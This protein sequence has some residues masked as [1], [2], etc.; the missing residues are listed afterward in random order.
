MA[1]RST[2]PLSRLGGAWFSLCLIGL[3]LFALPGMVLLALNLLRMESTVNVWLK[4]K[5][6]ITYHIAVPWYASL[7]LVLV[8][9]LIVLLYFLKLKRKPLQV[10]STFLWKK[11]IEDLHVNS[12][13]Q[14][15]REN[16]LLLLQVLTVL[17]LIYSVLSFQLHGKDNET[18]RFIL[19]IDNS[20]S[21]SATDVA[22]SRLEQAKTEALTQVDEHG[23]DDSGM[24]IV[25]NSSAEIRQ[26]YTN[27]KGSLRR[28][29][30]SIEQTMR[31]TRVDEALTLAD[32][33]ANPQRSA[34]DK[35]GQPDNVEPGQ[36]RTIAAPE[37][38]PTEVHLYS[39]GR[40]P[41]VPDFVLGNLNMQFHAI[42]QPGPGSVDNVAIVAFN[43]VR[44]DKDARKLQVLTRIANYRDHP[45]QVNVDLEVIVNGKASDPIA[46]DE[47]KG[48]LSL[49]PRTV[50]PEAGAP[51]GKRDLAGEGYVTF[52]INDVDE[53]ANV[54]L[55]AQLRDVDG[56]PWRDHF[57]AD[58]EAWLVVGVVRKARVLI[59]GNPNKPLS[60]FFDQPAT[61]RVAAVAYLTPADL[62]NDKL[63]RQ[64]AREGAFDLV[65]FDRCSPE[66]GPKDKEDAN[67]PLANTFFIDAVPPP[68]EKPAENVPDPRVRGWMKEH[69]LL[70]YISGLQ[71]IRVSEAFAFNFKDAPPRTPRLLE[72]DKDQAL[73]FALTRQTFTDVVLT[74]AIIDDNGF[75]VTNW[76]QQISFPLFLRN[77]LYDK[78][79]VS[80][81]ASEPTLQAGMVK[82]L[83]PDATVSKVEVTDPSGRSHTLGRDGRAEFVFGK[84]DLLGAYAVDWDGGTRL[85]A[86]NLLDPDESNLEPRGEIS[87]G[88]AK[89]VSGVE[90]SQPRD[91]WKWMAG[92]ALLL[93][94]AEW[95]MYNRRIFI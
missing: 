82:I 49:P 29:I 89:I 67:M 87:I 66:K 19:I 85:F 47:P 16:V 59:V 41:D 20:A 30:E 80:D 65:I 18:R 43:A 61:Q 63:Y 6:K 56:K 57:Q 92:A 34:I 62:K 84:T 86:V 39:D 79:N 9:F 75:W 7:I 68:M 60:D 48:P 40:F 13:F 4:E 15:L 2:N 83:R 58:N 91:L 76:P 26:A 88:A 95:Y 10:P 78:G 36:E 8:P 24:V 37:G 31:P 21:M 77:L 51:E 35:I 42:G 3:L 46:P 93:A 81:A 55:H 14:W 28:A 73:M 64:P 52:Q 17:F 45:A 27:D 70:Q 25:F 12:L 72:S 50:A 71:D 54:V 23:P 74:F 38:V 44:D 90:Q 5:F 32:S 1:N 69:P 33:L 22:P 53:R 11:S 94:V